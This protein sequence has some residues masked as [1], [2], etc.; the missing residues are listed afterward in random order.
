MIDPG[1]ERLHRFQRVGLLAAAAALIAVAAFFRYASG[2]DQTTA[3]WVFHSLTKVSLLLG[4]CSL[5][6]TQIMW[7]RQSTYGQLVLVGCLI[8]AMF[9]MIRPK[10]VVAVV[11]FIAAGVALM[12]S[13]TFLRNMLTR[14]R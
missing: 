9:F 3:L 6:W 13:L 2:L 5:A 1:T 7:L 12:C 14:S 10:A 11:P 4:A 8:A